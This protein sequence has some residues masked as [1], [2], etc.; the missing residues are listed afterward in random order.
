V[1]ERFP[2]APPYGGAFAHI[3]P[4]LTIAHA[5]DR[6]QLNQIAQAFEQASQG[7][8]PILAAVNEVLLLDNTTG[9]WQIRANFPLSHPKA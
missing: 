4:H 6:D 9:R 7:K 5:A 1:A 3:I 8:L 2:E